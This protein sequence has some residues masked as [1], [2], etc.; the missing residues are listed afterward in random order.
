MNKVYT[1]DN[2]GWFPCNTVHEFMDLRKANLQCT[3]VLWLQHGIYVDFGV[4][5][6]LESPIIIFL[7]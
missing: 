7:N 6:P 3:M 4:C 1:I 5:Y 2:F